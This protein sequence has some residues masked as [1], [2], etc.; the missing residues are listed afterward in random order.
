MDNSRILPLNRAIKGSLD[1][2][3]CVPSAAA[4]VGL[5]ALA[6]LVAAG[7]ELG[8]HTQTHTE[9]SIRGSARK[10]QLG[11][12]VR[13]GRSKGD[14]PTTAVADSDRLTGD[15]ACPWGQQEGYQIG[16]LIGAR[17]PATARRH[18]G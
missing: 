3:P 5:R 7:H 16:D 15:G 2:P 8:N 12:R 1:D 11:T 6:T 13:Q 17:L 18:V 10:T 14:R 4:C 9:S